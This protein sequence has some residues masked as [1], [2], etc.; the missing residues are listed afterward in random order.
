MNG[1]RSLREREGFTAARLAW[2][3]DVTERSVLAWEYGDKRPRPRHIEALAKRLHVSVPQL[4][5]A[6]E[7]ESTDPS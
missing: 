7:E 1:L 4:E 6:L 3:V 2:A 5:A